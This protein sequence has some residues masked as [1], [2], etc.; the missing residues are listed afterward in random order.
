LYELGDYVASGGCGTVMMCR[1]RG[2]PED[3]KY[4]LK[5]MNLDELTFNKANGAQREAQERVDR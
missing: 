1:K 2:D 4:I 5:Y 3:V